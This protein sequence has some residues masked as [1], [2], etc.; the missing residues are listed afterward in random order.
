MLRKIFTTSLALF[1]LGLLFTSCTKG[2]IISDTEDI[3][4]TWAVTGIR[5]N[6]SYDW[7]GDGRSETDIYGSYS[8]CQRDIILVL[9]RNGNGQ[10]RQGCNASWQSLYWDLTNGNRTLNIS[11]YG[12]DLNLDLTQ[13]SYNTI[14][15]EDHVTV[16]GRDFVITY[17]LSRR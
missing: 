10:S 9:D 11:L 8:S 16:N 3:T 7:D 17:T 13:L 2:T 15:G 14:R 4:G 6:L 5:S 1:T 12:D